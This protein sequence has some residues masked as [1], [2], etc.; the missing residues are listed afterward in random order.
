MQLSMTS[1]KSWGIL[2]FVPIE[3][4]I[5]LSVSLFAIYEDFN[6]ANHK[7]RKFGVSNWQEVGGKPLPILLLFR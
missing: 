1:N 2:E 5:H 3:T 6:L 7:S 4:G